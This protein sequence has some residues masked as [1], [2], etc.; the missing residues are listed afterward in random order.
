MTGEAAAPDPEERPRFTDKRRIDPE[1]GQIRPEAAD[2]TVPDDASALFDEALPGAVES[3]RAEAAERLADLQRLQAEYVNYRKRVE[4]DRGVAREA[5]V[6]DV[7]DALVGALD[8]IELA[9]Q[10]GELGDGPFGSIAE[11]VEGALARFGWERYGA[12]GEAFDPTVHEAIMQQHSSEVTEPTVTA[13]ARP[14][15]RVGERVLRAAQV[16]VTAPAE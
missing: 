11:K 3:A 16:V 9:R 15:H 1:T 13:V 2:V 5:A 10:H 7:V 8:E 6:Q 4:R 14:G 12:V